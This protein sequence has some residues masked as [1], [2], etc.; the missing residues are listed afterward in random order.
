MS[1]TGTPPGE[2]APARAAAISF[3]VLPRMVHP[4]RAGPDGLPEAPGPPRV[5]VQLM[6]APALAATQ[7][8]PWPA[9]RLFD[10]FSSGDLQTLTQ[11]LGRMLDNLAAQP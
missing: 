5:M 4:A 8:T 10:G 6:R 7:A 2:A 9:S 3:G 1:M 11:M